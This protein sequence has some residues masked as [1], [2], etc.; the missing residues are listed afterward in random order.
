MY[1]EILVRIGFMQITKLETAITQ[2]ITNVG[3]NQPFGNKRKGV[4]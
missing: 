1:K 3:F 2:F 4:P